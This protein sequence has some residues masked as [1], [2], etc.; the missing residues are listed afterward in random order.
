MG[1]LFDNKG[2]QQ[3]DKN[4]LGSIEELGAYHQPDH[5]WDEER[6]TH[7]LSSGWRSLGTERNGVRKR[8]PAV[9]GYG[10][11]T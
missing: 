9:G 10:Q 2:H 3:T 6:E 7:P 1:R 4:I 5:E 8:R 11:F